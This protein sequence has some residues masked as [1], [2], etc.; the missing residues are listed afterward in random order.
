MG[1]AG[2]LL[3]TVVLGLSWLASPWSVSPAVASAGAPIPVTSSGQNPYVAV[4]SQG[5]AHIVWDGTGV[6]AGNLEYCEIPAGATGCTDQ[7]AFPTTDEA[8]ARVLLG[9]AAGEVVLLDLG[10]N[11]GAGTTSNAWVSLDGGK[12]FAS[13]PNGAAG[14][15]G[16]GWSTEAGTDAVR[17][18]D[19]QIPT[20]GPGGFSASWMDGAGWF[21][22]FPVNSGPA[23][24]SGQPPANSQ[25]TQLFTSCGY[26]AE[27]SIAL[28][29]GT[30]PV[31]EC[32][33]TD[34]AIYYRVATGQGSLDDATTGSWGPVQQVAA[35]SG[36]LGAWI[37]G[38]PR[39]VFLAYDAPNGDAVVS[40]LINGMFGAPTLVAASTFVEGI[41]EDAT[42]N[43]F[44]I[45]QDTTQGGQGRQQ[46]VF[47]SGNG[48]S[49]TEVPLDLAGV[50]AGNGNAVAQVSGCAAATGATDTGSGFAVFQSVASA[51][52]DTIYAESIGNSA[53]GAF[54]GNANCPTQLTVG[55]AQLTATTSCFA[56]GADGT[57]TTS[58]KVELNGMIIT[59][60]AGGT[61]RDYARVH[62]AA[63]GQLSID[64]VNGTISTGNSPAVVRASTIVLGSKP[65]DWL[66]P[67]AAGG[68]LTNLLA[69]GNP[70]AFDPSAN[71]STLLGFNINGQVTPD[72]EPGGMASLPMNVQMPSP[73]G[74]F[75][76][77]APTDDV[78]LTSGN[79][80]PGGLSI[81]LHSININIP[82]VSLGIA[83][84][85]PFNI[86]Y[87]SD[88]SIFDG[89][90]G[91]QLPGLSTGFSSQWEFEQGR[92]VYG[93][94]DVNFGMSFPIYPDVFL[95]HIDIH[96]AGKRGNVCA[97]PPTI[98]DGPTAI[99]G[100]LT[101]A[102]GPIVLGKALASV[103]GD[104]TYTFPESSCHAPGVFAITGTGAIFGVPLANADAS[105][106]TN[107]N[108]A[109]GGSVTLGSHF[110]GAFAN[111]QG[112][113]GAYSPFPFYATGGADAYIFGL[114]PF[115]A[116][117]TVS[118]V[119]L[120]G[121]VNPLG[122]VGY[123]WGHGLVGGFLSCP[124]D[125]FVPQGLASRAHAANA[126]QTVRVPS[127]DPVEGI[128]LESAAGAP[129]VTVSGPGGARITTS[130][131]VAGGPGAVTETA[132]A[133]I[134]VAT[135]VHETYIQLLH[136]RAGTWT[137][138]PAAGSPA[139]T[140]L[141]TARG[142]API[143]VTARVAGG[144]GRDRKLIYTNTPAHGRVVTLFEHGAG[145]VMRVIANVSGARGTLTFH[146]ERGP[147]GLRTIYAQ[148]T[149]RGMADGK[150]IKVAT[151]VAPGPL[152][153]T[154][155]QHVQVVR[156]GSRIRIS[157]DGVSGA[158][159]Y[160]VRA[161]LADGRA[162]LLLESPRAR[163][164]LVPAVP[165]FDA[166]SVMVAAMD[167]FNEP[168]PIGTATLKAR[169]PTCRAPAAHRGALV[170]TG[171]KPPKHQ[172]H[173]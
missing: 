54:R 165:G 76:G 136:P 169:K 87:D 66:I 26:P 99:G 24:G 142:L 46:R 150:P 103:S 90:I 43:L 30:T 31:A 63:A 127:N 18:T 141:E 8:A 157:W 156:V 36:D 4:D 19:E 160:V 152:P 118:S 78:D 28:L 106:S 56:A 92:F 79:S 42:G 91:L 121:C 153:L 25:E 132:S 164:V 60:G 7:Q 72:L 58:G 49:W 120:L 114:G 53:C 84:L 115:G 89:D 117:V 45:T 5:T 173:K 82:T 166:G 67:S 96:V 137:I 41:S 113:I 83:T 37:A 57:Y 145:G 75:I 52:P 129:Q 122:Y 112:A 17:F 139:I 9:P 74:G 128:L 134:G 73:I 21:E 110:L 109:F 138:Q 77:G 144:A 162:L 65:F 94:A 3:V 33:N 155:P 101:V 40:E 102:L 10:D 27:N 126:A 39:G 163:S 105:F 2:A 167:T 59:P 148:V 95:Q 85:S 140:G 1:R 62:S 161:M 55:A 143:H 64:T 172:K 86:S 71:G 12:T 47:T 29:N 149:E 50:D 147:A 22:N 6:D 13:G 135:A 123:K 35:Q 48:V 69:S 151:Y 98:T 68:T 131:P 81:G 146:P 88:P 38:G 159:R 51:T 97:N 133:D 104:A 108:I 124:T 61:S 93:A 11:A 116:S 15:A 23:V 170:C 16:G 171:T 130:A 111:F 119:G 80:I 32:Y 107:G 158:A 14:V 34:G 168:G 44:L 125:D 70:V 20:F 100:G 154:R